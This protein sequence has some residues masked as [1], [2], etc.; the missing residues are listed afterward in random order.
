MELPPIE[1]L[2]DRTAMMVMRKGEMIQGRVTDEDGQPIANAR[3]YD[4]EYYWFAP[5]KPRAKTGQDGDFHIAGVK[6][7][8]MKLTVQAPGCAPELIDVRRS[9]KPLKIQ[10]RPGQAILG[11][12][13]DVN[14]R[15]IERVSVSARR[16]R[17]QRNRLHLK[18]ESD[19]DGKFRL[20]DAPTDAVEYDLGKK[21]YLILEYFPMS[22]SPDDYSVT[23]K[24]PVRI[25]GSVVDAETG[26]PLDKFSMI[27]GTDYDD[28][29]AP[30]WMR[31]KTKTIT[32]GRYETT[33]VQENFLFRVRVEAEGYMPA[34]SRIFRAYDPDEGVVTYDFK[35]RKAAPLTG[36]VLGL[37]GE[38]LADAEV[39][40]ATQRMNI[41]NG[42]VSHDGDSLSR[43]TDG[44]G[45][46]EF[47]PEVEPFCLVAV[48]KQG[49][50]MITEEQFES[51]PNI[52]IRPWTE[53][54]RRLQIIRRPTDGQHVDFPRTVR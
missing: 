35:L 30:S 47:P 14:G 10:L 26:N 40:L 48:H 1:K 20:T 9:P 2:F 45:R 3:I 29:R 50:G 51:S 38:P 53:E 18:A 23:L 21:G 54:N 8:P 6:P 37:D 17:G 7:G 39:Y 24:A 42:K 25:I 32:N 19:A 31:Y 36:T 41:R 4:S 15:P 28:G 11:R 13:V 44:A 34:E 33:I 12:V 22:P 46:F 43:K 52:S 16:W 27:M 49:I 5:G